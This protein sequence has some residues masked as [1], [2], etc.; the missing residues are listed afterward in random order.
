MTSLYRYQALNGS[1][2]SHQKQLLYYE[3]LKRDH[4]E[5]NNSNYWCSQKNWQRDG[6]MAFFNKGW[7]IVIH[8][9][10][11]EKEEA[12]AL[13]DKIEFFKKQVVP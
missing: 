3:A 1:E 10:S 2:V 8:Y 9:N 12:E 6:T 5:Q 13:A 11:S 7:D 4:Y